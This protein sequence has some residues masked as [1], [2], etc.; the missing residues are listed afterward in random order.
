MALIDLAG[1]NEV[2]RVGPPEVQSILL[3]VTQGAVVHLH[4]GELL[5]EAQAHLVSRLQVLIGRSRVGTAA[6][7]VRVEV[8]FAVVIAEGTRRVL[9]DDQVVVMDVNRGADAIVGVAPTDD[10]VDEQVVSIVGTTR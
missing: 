7:I 8:H 9:V 5:G 3:E 4:A 1:G 10:Q 2:A 6:A